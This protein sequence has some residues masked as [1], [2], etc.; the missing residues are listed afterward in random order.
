MLMYDF[1]S[2]SGNSHDSFWL[3]FRIYK[4]RLENRYLD[5]RTISSIGIIHVFIS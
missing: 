3:R 5:E 2:S 1:L 4:R